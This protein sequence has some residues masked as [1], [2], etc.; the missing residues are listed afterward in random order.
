[1]AVPRTQNA[2]FTIKLEAVEGIYQDPSIVTDMIESAGM[3]IGTENV[4]T[5][6]ENTFTGSLRPGEDEIGAVPM[7]VAVSTPLKGA[8]AAGSLPEADELLRVCGMEPVAVTATSAIKSGGNTGNGVMGTI[9]VGTTSK[10]G[11]YLLRITVAATNAGTFTVTDPDGVLAGTGTVGVSFVGGGLTFTL[12]DGVTDFIVGDGFDI[13]GIAQG[14]IASGIV[15]A[16]SVVAGVQ[17]F[18]I[19]QA[20]DTSWPLVTDALLGAVLLVDEDGVG[21][22]PFQPCH[23]VG[24]SFSALIVTVQIAEVAGNI[25]SFTAPLTT[26]ARVTMTAQAR[27]SFHDDMPTASLGCYRGGRKW[28]F[29]GVR[30]EGKLTWPSGNRVLFDAQLTGKNNGTNTTAVPVPANSVDS[31]PKP[32]WRRGRALLGGV[33]VPV[34]QCVVTFGNQKIQP[35]NPNQD[36]ALDATCIT[37]VDPRGT[38][39]PMTSSPTVR[40]TFGDFV[41]GVVRSLVCA[42][43]VTAAAGL[44]ISMTVPR[45]KF[46]NVPEGDRS[47]Y[48]IDDIA[49]Q[50]GNK[51]AFLTYW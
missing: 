28:Q 12:A 24:Y 27:Y 48:A 45:V 49:F 16:A 17:Q 35:E 2:A 31:N 15:T 13:T 21:A 6:T 36:E 40:N 9:T 33:P 34:N 10:V 41:S 26:T 22:L 37:K 4:Q 39:N 19:N 18:S 29:T 43:D 51:G 50:V 14:V 25:R 5:I 42:T 20:V 23:V 44:R 11:I 3:Q 30:G 47:G 38:F 1:M 7:A 8:S 32:R 46:M